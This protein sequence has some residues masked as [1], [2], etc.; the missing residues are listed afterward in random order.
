MT[1]AAWLFSRRVDL[2]AFGGSALLAFA[3]VAA[4]FLG[5]DL[6]E[7]DAPAPEW[8]WIG[9]VLLIDVAHVWGTAVLVYLD[10]VELKRRPLLYGV[11]PAA[12][13]AIGWAIA[14]ES[15][16]WFWRALAYL[17]VVH[18]VRQQVGFVKL[19]RARAGERSLSGRV[20]DEGTTYAVTLG[21]VVWWHANLPSSIAWMTPG[22]FVRGTPLVLGQAALAVSALF[23]AAYAVRAA[24]AYARGCGQP[25]KDLLVA[26]TALLWGTG[27]VLWGNDTVFT[28]TNVIAH[29]VPYAVLVMWTARQ[30]IALDL[31]VSR[32]ARAGVL[33]VLFSLWGF[34]FVEEVLWDALVWRQR[35]WL[36]FLPSIESDGARPLLVAVLALPQLTHYVLDGFYWRRRNNPVLP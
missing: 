8:V 23:F 11:V 1:P 7:R 26:T 19:Y 33:A 17:A 6:Q 24:L 18:F 27:I 22:D 16:L 28:L 29:G 13:L 25:G 4:A 32:V 3:L 34:A 9:T 12:A 20:I 31:S 5:G 36:T 10:P 35:D 21:P 30:R 15:E 14:S 2:L